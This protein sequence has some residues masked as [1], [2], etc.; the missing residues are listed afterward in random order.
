MKPFRIITAAQLMKELDKYTY[1]QLHIHHTWR[2][3][4]A[5]FTGS[6]HQALQEGMANYHINH[7][8]WDDIAQHVTLTP[9]GMFVTGRAFGTMPISIKGWN[10]GAFAVE[11]IGDFDI[12]QEKLEGKQRESIIELAR[13]FSRRFGESSIKFHREGPSVTKTCPGSG[14]SKADFIEEVRTMGKVYKDVPDD[15]WSL[16]Y[17]EAADKLGFINPDTAGNFKPQAALTREEAAVV[18]VRVY[19]AITGKKV[20]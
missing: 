18:S 11:M 20:V 4:K 2:P 14:L 15:R 19:E 12:G 1:K 16:K 3:T 7:N 5:N 13:Y 9:D 8:G 10:T 6:N 17:L